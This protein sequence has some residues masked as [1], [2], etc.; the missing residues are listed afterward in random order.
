MKE[1]L[2]GVGGLILFTILMIHLIKAEEKLP[3]YKK[4]SK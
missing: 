3:P 4:K 2:L 1:L